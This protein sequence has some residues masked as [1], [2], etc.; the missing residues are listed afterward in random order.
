MS[1]RRKKLPNQKALDLDEESV[2]SPMWEKLME[3]LDLAW[4]ENRIDLQTYQILL[5]AL[6]ESEGKNMDVEN[7]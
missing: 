7:A 6:G 3:Q 4:V 2:S 1:D 5:E